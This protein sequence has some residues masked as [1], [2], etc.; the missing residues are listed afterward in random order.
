MQRA[1]KHLQRE[2]RACYK[3]EDYAKALDFFNRA[4]GRAATVQLLDNR[5]ACLEKL[6]QLP[7]ALKDAKQAIQLQKEDPTG[8]LRAGKILIK[9]GK[10]SVALELYVHG[11]KSVKHAGQGYEVG[12][13]LS[14]HSTFTE[15]A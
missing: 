10:E 7:R 13:P 11:L 1:Q 6:H 9:M 8:Y 15:D 14:D 5:A 2:G 3:R 4:I 12:T